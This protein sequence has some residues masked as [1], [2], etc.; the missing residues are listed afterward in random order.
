[1]ELLCTWRTHY[2]LRYC[3]VTLIQTA[4]SAGTVYLLIAIQAT[5]GT[6]KELR[7]SLDQ[8]TLVQQYLQE[9]GSSWKCAT[10]ISFNLRNIMNEQVKPHLELMN[11]K[12]IPTSPCL[13]ISAD[14]GDD[15]E[16]NNS[17]R[18][19]SS[20]RNRSSVNNSAP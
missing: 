14:I 2:K 8:E 16:E 18:S 20:S 7:H 11:R 17:S 12:N 10:I 19:R 6:Q 5:S 15:D 1:M 4:F 3:P 9:I 13:H